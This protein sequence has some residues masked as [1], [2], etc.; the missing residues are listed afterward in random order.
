MQRRLIRIGIQPLAWAVS[1]VG[2]L[3]GLAQTTTH[4]APPPAAP[5]VTRSAS[6]VP[7]SSTTAATA[8]TQYSIGDPT[9]EEQL[10]LEYINRARGNP[11]AE[12]IRLAATTDPEVLG[13]YQYFGVNL[14]LMQSQ[15]AVIVPQPP[16]SMNALLLAAARAHS[17][18][19]LNNAYQGHGDSASGASTVVTRLSSYTS[20]AN[21][22]S[23]G[24]NVYSY[25]KSVLYGH[26]GFEVDWGGTALTGG[27]QNPAGHRLN[28]HSATFR[29]IG[30]GVVLGSNGSVGPQLVTQ[31]FGAR[32]DV[33]P[34]VTGVVY[35]DKNNNGFYD[36][37]EGIGG[38]NVMVSGSNFY[39]VTAASGGYSVP[40]PGDGTYVVTF[41]GGSVPSA[42]RTATVAAGSS[43]KLDYV[44]ATLATP[45]P[46]PTA[47]PSPTATPG[48]SA[49]PAPA[50]ITKLGNI[51][52]R[53]VAGT[54]DNA[55]IGGFIVTGSQPKRVIIRG[56]GPSLP[57]T[58]K[59][60]N[61]T[62]ELYQQGNST[63]IATNDNWVDA[64]NKQEI[65]ASTV[66]PTNDLEAAIL[67]TL[68]ANNSGY[69]A[70]VRGL[71]GGTGIGL[72]EIYDLDNAANSRL[73]NISTRAQVQGSN[74]VLIAGVIAVGPTSQK[75]VIRALGPSL[76]AAGVANALQDPTLD[77]VDANG[78]IVR[79]NDNWSDTQQ[80]EII[81]TGVPPA[82]EKEAALVE[83]LLPYPSTYTAVV[84]GAAGSTGVALVEVY[85]LQ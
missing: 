23:L 19:M 4:M 29:E 49:T 18:N 47:T 50:A 65:I 52:T 28:I 73:A 39:A 13:A 17:V 81:A 67:T 14:T 63:P 53:A 24:E 72:V 66:A 83:T 8:L 9:G 30:V 85:A 31:E 55:L 5:T 43:V 42:S 80:S 22:Y 2:T 6:I 12:G 60:A 51:S 82:S 68:P 33:L 26:A 15:F 10:Y 58:G 36:A 41:S 21:G 35:Q 77:L 78:A 44:A 11:Q 34:F 69:T 61:P 46:I 74:N 64:G 45:T 40:V 48:P 20:G 56:I 62:L 71:N 25:A 84:R 59:L 16:L 7:G 70:V 75:V 57:L 3:A 1:F 76:T 54:A 27:M 79:S 32:S 38:V 37:G